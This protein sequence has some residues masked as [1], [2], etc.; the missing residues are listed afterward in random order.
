MQA[1]RR[2]FHRDRSTPARA[3]PASMGTAVPEVLMPRG[4]PQPSAN[5]ARRRR[6]DR[7]PRLVPENEKTPPERG[8]LR[9]AILGSNQ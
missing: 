4:L 8:F 6:L 9:W 7:F 3:N 1:Y 2:S 5:G